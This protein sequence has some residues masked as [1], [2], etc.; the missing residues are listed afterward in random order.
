V[1]L[2]FLSLNQ[3]TKFR[4][5]RLPEKNIFNVCIE[6]RKYVSLVFFLNRILCMLIIV[7]RCPKLKITIVDDNS[8]DV[9]P[10]V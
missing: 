4:V 8:N 9:S 10:T 3:K 7:L 2:F 1:F 6:S 5:L